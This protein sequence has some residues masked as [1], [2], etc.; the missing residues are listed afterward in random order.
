MEAALAFFPDPEV[1][2]NLALARLQAGKNLLRKNET[3]MATTL[4]I[5]AH[6]QRP[7]VAVNCIAE[8]LELWKR[9]N[10]KDAILHY[11]CALL[12]RPDFAEAHLNIAL[13]YRDDGQL[14]L[15]LQHARK[16]AT[17]MPGD[18]AAQGLLRSLE[19]R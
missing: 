10:F 4:L 17:L 1:E 2:T 9:K 16:G 8:G 14:G 6:E 13:A 15:A 19:A 3:D 7:G 18:P 12:M 5:A 11:R